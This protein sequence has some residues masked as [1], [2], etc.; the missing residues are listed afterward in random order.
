[1]YLVV[2]FNVSAFKARNVSIVRINT[3]ISKE[4]YKWMKKKKKT[5]KKEDRE[6]KNISEVANKNEHENPTKSCYARVCRIYGDNRA[7]ERNNRYAIERGKAFEKPLR[8]AHT[9]KAIHLTR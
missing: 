7:A 2:I 6:N 9:A 1:M 4:R 3:Q 5:R 8:I